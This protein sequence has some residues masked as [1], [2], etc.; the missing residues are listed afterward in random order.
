MKYMDLY[1][2][3]TDNP[4]GSVL[5]ITQCTC[6]FFRRTTQAF[7]IILYFVFNFSLGR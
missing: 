3:F 6:N 1:I 2:L 4:A 5:P 7:W